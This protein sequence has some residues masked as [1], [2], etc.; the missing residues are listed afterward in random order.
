MQIAILGILMIINLDSFNHLYKREVFITKKQVGSRFYFCVPVFAGGFARVLHTYLYLF[1][2]A[3]VRVS[4]PLC[5]LK[6]IVNNCIYIYRERESCTEVTKTKKAIKKINK[7]SGL[8]FV[9]FTIYSQLS[10]EII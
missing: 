5:P 3:Y 6:L 7:T 4:K 2:G 10:N 1:K 9:N 8:S